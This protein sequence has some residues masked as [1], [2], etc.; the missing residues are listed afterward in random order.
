MGSATS[1]FYK[2]GFPLVGMRKQSESSP[3]SCKLSSPS[4]NSLLKKHAK[5]WSKKA[6]S[7]KDAEKAFAANRT[8]YNFSPL[9]NLKSADDC[10]RY[11]RYY[12]TGCLFMDVQ[13]KWDGR[14]SAVSGNVTMFK[15]A[16]DYWQ[17]AGDME[18]CFEDFFQSVGL[19][20]APMISRLTKEDKSLI[21]FVQDVTKVKLQTFRHLIQSGAVRC[22]LNVKEVQTKDDRFAEEIRRLNPAR[23]DWSNLPDYMDR[24]NFQKFAKKCSSPETVHTFHTMNWVRKVFGAQCIDYKDSRDIL[25]KALK[26]YQKLKHMWL[27]PVFGSHLPNET[28]ELKRLARLDPPFM[29]PNKEFMERAAADFGEK[30]VKYFLTTQDKKNLNMSMTYL[31]NAVNP[32]FCRSDSTI[33]AAF[34]FSEGITLPTIEHCSLLPNTIEKPSCWKQLQQSCW[35][36]YL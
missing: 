33:F 8:P 6:I 36:S 24:H 35:K 13:P 31:N 17:R 10:V 25:E 23:I 22:H 9:L 20:T 15:N 16:S 26:D 30:Y 34:S 32:L 11:A 12:F 27:D 28:R 5:I 29:H 7:V 21:K 19:S 3:L 1:L 4:N 2:C 14:T 18:N